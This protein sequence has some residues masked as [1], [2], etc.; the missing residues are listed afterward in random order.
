M[1]TKEARTVEPK[2]PAPGWLFP[3]AVLLALVAIGVG[4]T[5][6]RSGNLGAL[7]VAWAFSAG[8]LATVNPCGWALLPSYAA[9]YL[10]SNEAGYEQ[11]ST[12]R[13]ASEG[14]RLGLLMTAGFLVIFS[15]VG[16]AISLGLRVLVQVMPFLAILVGLGLIGLGLWLLFGGSLRISIPTPTINAQARNPK[17]VFAY[18]LAYGFASLS[19]TLPIFLVVI[20][21]SLATGTPGEA[22]IMFASFG[23]GMAL[24]LMAVVFSI[25]LV[26]GAIVEQVQAV[27]PYVYRFGAALLI[28]AGAYL[29]W[30]QGRYLRYFLPTF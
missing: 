13:R 14:L 3:V 21:S 15:I 22:A 10:G 27:L 30:Y 17:S 9:Y 2:T 5:I 24:V 19:C 25:A 28:L 4:S 11:R 23:A 8:M 12:M 1:T 29:I 26:K 7:P 20:G 18:G 6:F 16:A